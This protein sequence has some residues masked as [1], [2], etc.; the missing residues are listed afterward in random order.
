MTWGEPAKRRGQGL[1]PMP[2]RLLGMQDAWAA[3]EPARALLAQVDESFLS[4]PPS[5]FSLPTEGARAA[6]WCSNYRVQSR[7]P[8]LPPCWVQ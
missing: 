5:S 4:T 2:E 7:G 1:S 8:L 6:V 3:R